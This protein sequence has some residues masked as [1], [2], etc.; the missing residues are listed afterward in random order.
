MA[1]LNTIFP[2][3]SKDA[4][5]QNDIVDYIL[6]FEDKQ[7]VRNSIRISGKVAVTKISDKTAF[8]DGSKAVYYD[9]IAGI[10]GAF[11]SITCSC[12]EVGVVEN[13]NEYPRYVRTKANATMTSD[14]MCSESDKTLELKLGG[15]DVKAS[16]ALIIGDG[17]G[18]DFSMKPDVAFNKSSANLP[19]NKT[20]V[21]KLSLR[22]STNTQFLYGDDSATFQY[23]LSD[24]QLHYNTVPGYKVDGPISMETI[25][26]VK[27]NAESN[28]TSISTR[29]PAVVQSASIVFHEESKLNSAKFNHLKSM[30]PPDIERVEF[31]MND[32]MSNYT[33][34]TLDTVQDIIYNYQQSWG[35]PP[36]SKSNLDNVHI[37]E[38]KD[39]YGIGMPFGSMIDMSNNKFGVSILSSIVSTQKYGVFMF[40]RGVTSL[41]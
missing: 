23:Q 33:T 8:V 41:K 17:S 28:N 11:Q 18:V 32:T 2:L 14:Q 25:H 16:T 6:T 30:I 22:L 21:M 35:V 7:I 31:T 26:H 27:T 10:S 4:Y 37:R 19:F 40:F 3:S 13:Q 36:M 38:Y 9:S 15:L 39:A 24:L 34:Y 1:T 5:S 20:G 12:D 29:V